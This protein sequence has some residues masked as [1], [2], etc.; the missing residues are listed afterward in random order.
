MNLPQ[1]TERV[2]RAQYWSGQTGWQDLEDDLG[3]AYRMISSSTPQ[4][5][6]LTAL[7]TYAQTHVKWVNRY[8]IN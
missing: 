7:R 5:Q 1:G 2:I 4:S 8:S 6:G 3:G